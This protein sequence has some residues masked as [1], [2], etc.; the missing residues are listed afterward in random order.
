MVNLLLNI[1]FQLVG[2]IDEADAVIPRL[3]EFTSLLNQDDA[4]VL[5][6]LLK[7]AVAGRAGDKARDTISEVLIGM[8]L[9]CIIGKFACS[10]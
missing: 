2:Q 8:Q 1:Y 5:V 10:L 3:D 7:L 9:S 4:R 6:D